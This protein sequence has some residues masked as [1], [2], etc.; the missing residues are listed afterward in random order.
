M[1]KGLFIFIEFSSPE[2]IAGAPGEFF[3]SEEFEMDWM[4]WKKSVGE[5]I[6]IEIL[7]NDL[8]EKYQ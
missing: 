8:N 6:M 1:Y 4:D 3:A 7:L 2:M 5:K